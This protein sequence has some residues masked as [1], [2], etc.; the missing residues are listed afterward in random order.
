M[1]AWTL[2]ELN[3]MPANSLV[4]AE[5]FYTK[6]EVM[7]L[8]APTPEDALAERIILE[9]IRSGNLTIVRSARPHSEIIKEVYDFVDR[10]NKYRD[11][12][13]STT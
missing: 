9:E 6:T 11:Y 13:R 3:E 12:R 4:K 7:K 8:L 1:K 2:K 5:M 10:L